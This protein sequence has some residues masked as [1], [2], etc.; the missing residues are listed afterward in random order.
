MF[1][2][3]CYGSTALAKEVTPLS[4]RSHEIETICSFVQDHPHSYASLAVC[5]RAIDT[6]LEQVTSSIVDELRDHLEQAS[7]DEIGAYY[8]I[9]T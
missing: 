2:A 1:S 6:E 3:R 5:R 4:R 8:S 7:D 9:V